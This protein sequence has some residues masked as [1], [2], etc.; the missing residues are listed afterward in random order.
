MH[1]VIF[2]QQIFCF[3]LVS[4][5]KTFLSIWISS[6]KLYY[7]EIKLNG[8]NLLQKSKRSEIFVK[9]ENQ[10]RTVYKTFLSIWISYVTLKIS[11]RKKNYMNEKKS[12]WKTYYEKK[13]YP[14]SPPQ[15]L[16]Y[17]EIKLNGRNLL[18][19]SKW[20]EI[21]VK[22]ENQNRTVYIM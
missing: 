13:N 12:D 1:I 3:I 14:F 9:R 16:Y 11:L 10:N 7:E 22:R 21:F 20:S 8:R 15:K 5:Y 4:R 18:R 19:K 17:E 2:S 6:L